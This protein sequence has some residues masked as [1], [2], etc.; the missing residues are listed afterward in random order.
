[1]NS[2]ATHRKKPIFIIFLILTL[3][4][5]AF[6]FSNSINTGEDSGR[7]S[8]RVVQ[9]VIKAAGFFGIEI[10]NV[11]LLSY[12]VRKSAHFCEF[13]LLGAI[14]YITLKNLGIYRIAQFYFS[15]SYC[16]LIAS[17]DEYIQTFRDGRSGQV[18]DVLLDLSGSTT[19]IVLL[20]LIGLWIDKRKRK[21]SAKADIPRR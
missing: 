17:C 5:T 6:I 14:S 3:L 15:I 7:Q 9:A 11:D 13:A 4:C 20:F 2:N 16:L 8:G 10:S 21:R 19:A 12:I 18:S 1:M